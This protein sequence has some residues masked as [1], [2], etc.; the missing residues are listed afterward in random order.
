MIQ[1]QEQVHAHSE[2]GQCYCV[3]PVPFSFPCNTWRSGTEL[4]RT[5]HRNR[6]RSALTARSYIKRETLCDGTDYKLQTKRKKLNYTPTNSWVGL[7]SP[8]LWHS[9]ILQVIAP[10]WKHQVTILSYPRGAVI[11]LTS[12]S[13]RTLCW[14]NLKPSPPSYLR[15]FRYNLFSHLFLGLRVFSFPSGFQA[16]ILYVMLFSLIHTTLTSPS[17]PSWFYHPDNV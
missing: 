13:F 15:K 17:N 16:T 8:G 3:L 4:G 10:P 11:L 12:V 6:L 7:W 9:M 5:C 14:T 1:L 2:N